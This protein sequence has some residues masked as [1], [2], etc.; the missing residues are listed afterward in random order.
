MRSGRTSRSTSSRDP[1]RS[2]RRTGDGAR[3]RTLALEEDG[4]RSGRG[5]E[6]EHATGCG[7]TAPEEGTACF[8]P[9]VSHAEF[10]WSKALLSLAVVAAGLVSSWFVCVALYT[11][12]SRRLVGL[13]DRV[14]PLRAGLR[15]PRQQVLPR[16]PLRE[17]HRPWHRRADRRGRLLD[18]PV[19]HRR[20]RQRRRAG[21]TDGRRVVLPQHRPAGRRRR[22]R[23]RRDGGERDG[24]GAAARSS[25]ARST[26]TV[27][28]SSGR[29]PSAPSCS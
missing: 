15:L 14:R 24:I 21:G 29:L 3:R 4:G 25:Q 28:C 17:G 11:K 9:T 5:G 18:Q 19:R 12:R 27:R 22:R 16:R 20:H 26:S 10:K 13:T 6:E 2:T 8:F 7:F 23:R 1:T